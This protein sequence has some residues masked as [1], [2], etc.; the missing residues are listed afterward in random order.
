MAGITDEWRVLFEG[1]VEGRPV[2]LEIYDDGTYRVQTTQY[3]DDPGFLQQEGSTMLINSPT[4]EGRKITFEGTK[5][6]EIV[7]QLASEG[8]S[9]PAIWDIL[10]NLG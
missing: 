3:K 9:E 6:Q 8:F 2:K 7:E 5:P 4:E 1:I 10:K